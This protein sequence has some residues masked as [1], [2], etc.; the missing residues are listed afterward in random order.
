MRKMS[1]D[2]WRTRKYPSYKIKCLKQGSAAGVART[3]QARLAMPKM[4][5]NGEEISGLCSLATI[6]AVKNLLTTKS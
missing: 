5:F 6:E 1:R 3:R 4:K 2:S